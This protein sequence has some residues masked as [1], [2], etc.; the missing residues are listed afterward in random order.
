MPRVGY[1]PTIPEFER[2]TVI[3]VTRPCLMENTRQMIRLGGY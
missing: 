3:G 2:A 1:E